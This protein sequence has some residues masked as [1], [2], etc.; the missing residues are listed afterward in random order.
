MDLDLIF[1]L[2]LLGVA[3][4]IPAFV[5]AFADRRWPTGGLVLLVAGGVAVAYAIQE[6]GDRFTVANTPDVVVEV[7]GRYLN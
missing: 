4:A 6:D 3:F 7:L 2:G 1:V 5:S